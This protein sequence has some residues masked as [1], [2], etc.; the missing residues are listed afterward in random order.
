[1]KKQRLLVINDEDLHQELVEGGLHPKLIQSKQEWKSALPY[2]EVM[3]FNSC[4][5]MPSMPPEE[6]LFPV[7]CIL[8]VH[9]HV[10]DILQGRKSLPFTP[11]QPPSIVECDSE[12]KESVFG[13]GNLYRN[14]M[15]KYFMQRNGHGKNALHESNPIISTPKLLAPEM[16]DMITCSVHF[17][18]LA[19]SIRERLRMKLNRRRRAGHKADWTDFMKDEPY[20]KQLMSRQDA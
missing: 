3:T 5:R 12:L 11:W 20:L 7:F 18:N 4:G 9:E 1:M 6:Q 13:I 2:A 17:R 16:T 19:R 10:R 8:Q 14:V 15:Q